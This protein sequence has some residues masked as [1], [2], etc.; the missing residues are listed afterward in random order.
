MKKEK[1]VTE[2][3]KEIGLKMY[4]VREIRE[5]D[6]KGNQISCPTL[7]YVHVMVETAFGDMVLRGFRVLRGRDG[8][9]FVA[10]PGRTRQL[11]DAN[12]KPASKQRFNDIRIDGEK[13]REFEAT[14]S[15]RILSAFSGNSAPAEEPEE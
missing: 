10:R 11:F 7:A 6:D 14:L 4:K 12:G 9:P 5:R 15:E 1:V 2:L 8:N 3:S 13:D